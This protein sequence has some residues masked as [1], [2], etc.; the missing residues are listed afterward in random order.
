MFK[1]CY[2]SC[3][4]IDV[5]RIPVATSLVF[6]VEIDTCEESG[7]RPSSD[8]GV[9]GGEGQNACMMSKV[10]GLLVELEPDGVFRTIMGFL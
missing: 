6:R 4:S 2:C 3:T 7:S 8:T 5:A 9:D 1:P 10:V